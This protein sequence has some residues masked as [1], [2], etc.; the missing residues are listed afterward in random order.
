MKSGQGKRLILV[1]GPPGIGKTTVLLKVEEKL[2]NRG[3]KVGG[4][5]S[6]EIRDGCSRVG[7][8][9]TDLALGRK[10]WLAHIRQAEGPKIGRYRVNIED[11]DSIGTTAILGAINNADIVVI[12]EI[13]P[14]ELCSES[15]INAVKKAAE[16][17]K[18]PVATVHYRAHDPL[19]KQIMSR[20]DTEVFETTLRNRATLPD[21]VA[22][23][24][25][26]LSRSPP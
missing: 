25:T 2:R 26:D 18:P 9:I 23:K 17:T 16:A 22:S 4:M 12:D 10:G 6:Q 14:M 3:Y 20:G 7:F 8:E 24:V 13:G 19:I 11:L 15:F 1:T 21:I 5:I